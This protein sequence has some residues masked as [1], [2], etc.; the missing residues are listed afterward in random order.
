[1]S[2]KGPPSFFLIFCNKL[3]FQKAFYILKTLRF[4]SLRY[5]ADFRRSRLVQCLQT[6]IHANSAS[7]EVL[8]FEKINNR[9]CSSVNSRTVTAD[10]IVVTP[11][12][13][14]LNV[15]IVQNSQPLSYFVQ[16]LKRSGMFEAVGKSVGSV[17][18]HVLRLRKKNSQKGFV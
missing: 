10:H 11:N 16:C 3:E 17:A 13:D 6:L 12:V 5:S 2:P 18:I 7:S 9:K 15:S 1:M 8:K 4:L 14:C